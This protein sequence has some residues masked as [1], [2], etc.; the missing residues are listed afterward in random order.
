MK[1]KNVYFLIIFILIISVSIGY[2]INMWSMQTLSIYSD[3]SLIGSDWNIKL[4]T[5]ENNLDNISNIE[6]TKSSNNLTKTKYKFDVRLKEINDVYSF[7][8]DLENAGKKD[9]EIESIN[10]YIDDILIK[11]ISSTDNVINEYLQQDYLDFSLFYWD[12]IDV[13]PGDLLKVLTKDKLTVSVKYKFNDLIDYSAI[14]KDVS[15]SFEINYKD[16]TPT[17]KEREHYLNKN[18]KLGDYISFN[19]FVENST[20]NTIEL[21]NTLTGTDDNQ[22]LNLDSFNTWRVINVDSENNEVDLISDNVSTNS[23]I[24]KG[25]TGFINYVNI[26]NMISSKYSLDKETVKN[27]RIFGNRG[28]KEVLTDKD[29]E[30]NNDQLYD[31]DYVHAN[32][33]LMSLIAN[34]KDGLLSSYA[35]SSRYKNDDG[36]GIYLIND[37]GQL[38]HAILLDENEHEINVNNRLIITIKSDILVKNEG[39][40]GSPYLVE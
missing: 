1:N 28:Q 40:I 7:D 27:A 19:P 18:V 20:N 32:G 5:V 33:A 17:A 21:S 23:F 39:T 2:A 9:G 4:N 30:D 26:L 12:E 37:S 6:I 35:V 38:D 34:K 8:I 10:Y 16:K 31:Y 25:E 36:Y 22:L 3:I 24:I 29:D 13:K 15:L 14:N 11:K